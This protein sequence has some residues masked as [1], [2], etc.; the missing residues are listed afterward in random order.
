MKI[1][2]DVDEVLVDF[3]ENLIALYNQSHNACFRRHD[4]RSMRFAETWGG[5]DEEAKEEV[6][7]F[8][9]SSHFDEI[10]PISQSQYGIEKLKLSG[11]ELI[12]VTSRPES[13]R[14]RTLDWLNQNYL[15]AFSEFYFTSEWFNGGGSRKPD[16]CIKAGI[17]ILVDDALENGRE[18]SE[19]GIK[20]LLP[21]CPWNQTEDLPEGIK[22]VYSWEEIVREVESIKK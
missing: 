18:C 19:A 17:E 5:S 21:D 15:G 4:F 6:R 22:R 16:I 11:H 1:G 10:E 2:I 12:I 14:E 13:V 20:V 3:M 7:R 9:E 8:F